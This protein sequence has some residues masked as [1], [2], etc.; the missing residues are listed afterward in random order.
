MQLKKTLVS[1]LILGS[2]TFTASIAQGQVYYV[3]PGDSLYNIAARYG[4]SVP[5]LVQSNGIGN[6]QIYPG[7][8]LTIASGGN[9]NSTSSFTY[10]VRSG[11]SLFLLSQKFGVSVATLKSSNHLSGDYLVSG[12]QLTIPGGNIAN[13]STTNSSYRV[14]A[15][16]SIFLIAQRYGITGTALRAANNLSADAPI[17]PNQ[18]LTIPKA[19][20]I[21]SSSYYGIQLNQKD[22]DLLARL[23]TAESDGEP[24]IGQVAVAATIL[25]RL[26]DPLYPKTIPG[27]IYEVDNGRYQY[28]PVLDGRINQP[29][30]ASAYRAVQSAYSG[31]DPSNGANGFYNPAKTTNQWVSS[32]PETVVIGNHIFFNS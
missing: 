15:G 27:I 9:T 23:V 11:D 16:D 17:Y 29:A 30:S 20:S 12:K 31:W 2:L 26:R 1:A 19:V 18:S 32:Q 14:Q 6:N 7:Q 21:S 22:L 8:A 28:S 4:T 24:F 10:T 25:N 13:S 3:Q 5:A